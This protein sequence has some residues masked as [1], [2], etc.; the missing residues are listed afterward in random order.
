MLA[1]LGT[2]SHAFAFP[3]ILHVESEK[4]VALVDSSSTTSFIGP[5]VIEKSSIPMSNND[6]VKVTAANGNVL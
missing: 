2:A 3:L 1:L 6:P 5:T 4:L